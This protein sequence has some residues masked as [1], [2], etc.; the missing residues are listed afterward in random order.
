MELA[1]SFVALVDT[2]KCAAT[3]LLPLKPARPASLGEQLGRQFGRAQAREASKH[4][5]ENCQFGPDRCETGIF[6]ANGG[7]GWRASHKGKQ[8]VRLVFDRARAVHRIQLQFLEP[9]HD[10]Q[11]EFTLRWSRVDGGPSQEIVRQQWNFSPAGSTGELEDYEV[12]LEGVSA[13]VLEIR[14]DLTNNGAIATLSRWRV[15]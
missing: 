4:A 14:P 2:A 13:L 5:K 12:E 11:Q 8:A 7:S 1:R 10:R 15:G 9:E 3:A 6:S